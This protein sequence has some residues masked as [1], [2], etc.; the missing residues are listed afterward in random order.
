MHKLISKTEVISK[1]HPRLLEIYEF[2]FDISSNEGPKTSR[3]FAGIWWEDLYEYL[4]WSYVRDGD[5]PTKQHLNQWRDN[6]VE[7]CLNNAEV[8]K[9]EVCFYAHKNNGDVLEFLRSSIDNCS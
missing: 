1:S 5:R 4:N 3:I 7:K 6:V 9:S 8:C 2:S